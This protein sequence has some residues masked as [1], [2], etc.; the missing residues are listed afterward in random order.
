MLI[1]PCYVF[2]QDT[3]DYFS[4]TASKEDVLMNDEIRITVTANELG[5][6]ESIAGFRLN[7]EY[8]S[9]KLTLKRVDTSSQIESGTFRYH[10]AGDTMTGIYV[11]D[12][13][14]APQLTGEC[15]TLIFR[16]NDD[17]IFGDVRTAPLLMC[18]LSVLFVY[19]VGLFNIGAAGQYVAG[20]CVGLYAAIAW[21]LPWYLCLLLAIA[22]GAFLGAIS[23][24]LRTYCNVNVV[25]SGIMLNWI[26]LYL[27][28]LILTTVKQPNS[29]YTKSLTAANP[30]ALI[31]SLGLSKLFA[32]E[33]TVTIA[34]PLAIL[35]AVLVWVILNKTKFG[36]ELKA[37]G[38]NFNAAKYCGMKE[39]R[40]V[41]LTMVIAGGLAGM[42]AGLYYLTGIEDWETTISSVPKCAASSRRNFS[43]ASGK[44]A[45]PP[46]P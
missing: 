19:K 11:C 18:S 3:E 34:I 25:I 43:L 26:A 46:A 45:P 16:V 37:T 29:P 30:S 23:G 14:A 15:M 8:D 20:A 2:A 24:A 12:G 38:F 31:P 33:K 32:G 44:L 42:G 35:M 28:N 5:M 13:T 17:A 41:I 36:Y 7:V 39:N 9:S 27:T 6:N 22:A 1:S 40:N 10:I 21:Q 4:F